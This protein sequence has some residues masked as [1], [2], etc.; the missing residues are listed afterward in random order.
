MLGHGLNQHKAIHGPPDR[1]VESRLDRLAG[2]ATD[3]FSDIPLPEDHCLLQFD[4]VIV[5]PH[6]AAASKRTSRRLVQRAA[7]CATKILTGQPAPE[8]SI[9]NPEILPIWRGRT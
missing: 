3:V 2:F 7:E 1:V 8:G 9:L 5:T 6:V 4:N